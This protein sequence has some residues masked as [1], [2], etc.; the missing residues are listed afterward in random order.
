MRYFTDMG[1]DVTAYVAE[2]EASVTKLKAEVVEL[3]KQATLKP[4]AKKAEV[5]K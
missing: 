3:Q 5:K 2:L 1:G 4:A